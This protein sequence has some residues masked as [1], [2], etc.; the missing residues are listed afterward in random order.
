MSPHLDIEL[1]SRHP[2]ET[3]GTENSSSITPHTSNYFTED[4]ATALPLL[5]LLSAGFSFFVAGTNDGS[6]G[7][8]IPYILL[9]YSIG[10]SFI[11]ILYPSL[12]T[13]ILLT[14]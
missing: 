7:A 9:S 4:N 10:T 8:L 6:I 11:A 2:E 12:P 1:R 13:T 3:L 14:P 5:K